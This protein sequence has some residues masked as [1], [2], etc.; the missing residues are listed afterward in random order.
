ML[1]FSFVNMFQLLRRDR[2]D[3][4]VIMPTLSDMLIVEDPYDIIYDFDNLHAAYWK[5]SKGKRDHGFVCQYEANLMENLLKL[6]DRLER[7]VYRP[8]KPY[9]FYVYEPKKR[10]VCA[11]NFEDKVVQHSLCDNVLH[12]ALFPHLI[13]DNYASQ[14][15]KGTDDGLN[16]LKTHLTRFFKEYGLCGHIL[17]GDV[18]KFFDNIDRKILLIMVYEKIPSDDLFTFL[19]NYYKDPRFKKTGLPIGYQSS[20]V[21]AVFYLSPFDHF[22]KEQLGIKYYGRYMDDFFLIHENKSYL[23]ECEKAIRDFLSRYNMELNEKTNIFPVRNGIRFL[24][25]TSYLDQNGKVVQRLCNESKYKER[26]LLRYFR[27]LLDHD[28]IGFD[29]VEQSYQSWRAHAMRGNSF[30]LIANTDLYFN[31]LFHEEIDHF[32]LSYISDLVKKPIGN[33]SI[34]L[35]K[36][37]VPFGSL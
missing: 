31:D 25:F 24:G 27:E 18:K 14:P 19:S 7:R 36:E 3:V 5:S 12:P 30:Y 20:Q 9:F 32:G 6:S 17:R 22:V 37:G 15:G 1:A 11:N 34:N 2:K 4:Y 13:R 29:H 23:K 21:F 28:V 8:R 35:R 16:R 26:R 33:I 10:L